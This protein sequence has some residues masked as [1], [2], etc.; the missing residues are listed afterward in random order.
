MPRNI[1]P[2]LVTG[3]NRQVLDH[4][5]NLS[6]H[7]D[8]A[9]AL[10][11]AL[12]PLGDVQVFCPD[13]RTYRYMVASTKRIIFAAAFGMTT[14]AVRLDERMAVRAVASGAVPYPE[15]GQGWVSFTLFRD[16]WP[17]VDL[18]FWARKAYVAAREVGG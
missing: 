17:K 8:V 14:I 12:K 15:C 11:V 4:L 5:A 3:I 18:E 1:P 2:E 10:T 16:D 13:L 9:E 6:A 7:S